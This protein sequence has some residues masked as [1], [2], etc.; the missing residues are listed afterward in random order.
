[1]TDKK[2][3]TADSRQKA[4]PPTNE[5]P[6]D[7]ASTTTSTPSTTAGKPDAA[8]ERVQQVLDPRTGEAKR[9]KVRSI[10]DRLLAERG[11]REAQREEAREALKREL[12]ESDSPQTQR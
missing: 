7:R 9:F 3:S 11:Q 1:M 10:K 8:P 2:K 12:E 6:Q 4:D 5:P